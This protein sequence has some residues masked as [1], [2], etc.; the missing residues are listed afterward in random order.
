MDVFAYEP[1]LQMAFSD[2]P[3][4]PPEWQEAEKR[5]EHND[6]VIKIDEWQT[7]YAQ[8]YNNEI[9]PVIENS[10]YVVKK[11]HRGLLELNF[12]NFVGLSRIGTLNLEVRN[13]KI[14]DE[15]YQSML[16]ELAGNY[17]NLVFSFGTPVGQH[18]DKV[19]VGSKDSLFVEYLFLKKYLLDSSPDIEAI[20][21]ILAYDPHRSFIDELQACPIDQSDKVDEKTLLGLLCGPMTSLAEGHPLLQSSLGKTLAR[22][23]G[24]NIFPVSGVREVKQLT[25]DT[26]ENRFVKFFLKELLGKLEEL[27]GAL[28]SIET[29][30]FNPDIGKNLHA[31]R[32]KIARVLDHDMW[33]DVG[34]MRYV[35][36]NS[37]VLQRREGYRQLLRLFSLLQLSTCCDFLKTDFQ[38]LIEIKDLPTL[39]EYWCFFQVKSVMKSFATISKVSR[40]INETPLDHKLIPGLCLEYENGIKLLFNKTFSGSPGH[41]IL[42]DKQGDHSP[43]QGDSYSHNYCPDI[44]IEKGERRLI[45][46]AKYKGKHSGFYGEG[47]D[48]TVQVWKDEDLDKMHCYH[49]AIK[50]VEGSYILYPGIRSRIFPS[51]GPFNYFNGIG[52]LALRP[53]DGNKGVKA[54]KSELENVI[55]GFLYLESDQADDL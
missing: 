45:F 41:E 18:Y 12:R 34:Y 15:L 19:T 14:S 53:A 17:A 26:N 44:V 48:G 50:G 22:T 4:F 36:I 40:L 2:I 39:Y 42:T 30:Y 46:D 1:T 55:L 38:N 9:P 37:Q 28:A 47:E 16:D 13:R 25:V 3:D 21:N 31:L 52:A 24:I 8:F 49:D 11:I 35:P 20:G 27:E 5:S 29:S 7:Y 33:R 10:R 54:P 32:G 23:T 43:P 51:F 6:S